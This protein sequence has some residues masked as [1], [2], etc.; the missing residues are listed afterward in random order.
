MLSESQGSTLL[1]TSHEM[2]PLLPQVGNLQL[3]MV[4]G[5]HFGPRWPCHRFES[6]TYCQILSFGHIMGGGGRT[7]KHASLVAKSY[8]ENTF[9]VVQYCNSLLL[10]YSSNCLGRISSALE[11]VSLLVGAGRATAA[12]QITC[13]K[14]N[15]R[16]CIYLC[17]SKSCAYKQ[18]FSWSKHNISQ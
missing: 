18:F 10:A 16:L 14:Q 6:Q 2:Q 13:W 15:C 3:N 9:N 17:Y 8:T 7:L 1:S 12:R 4:T 5:Q 11:L